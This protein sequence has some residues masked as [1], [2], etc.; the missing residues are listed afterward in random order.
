MRTDEDQW[1]TVRHMQ[2]HAKMR[3]SEHDAIAELSDPPA[4]ATGNA[5]GYPVPQQMQR[6]GGRNT[7]KKAQTDR[8]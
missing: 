4:H 8:V 5:H 6:H 1:L 3:R 2:E 7:V